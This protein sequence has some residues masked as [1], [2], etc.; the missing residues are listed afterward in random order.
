MM[1]LRGAGAA[2]APCSPTVPSPPAVGLAA[3]GGRVLPEYF[4]LYIQFVSVR[5]QP[6]TAPPWGREAR[7]AAPWPGLQ[8][9]GM[10]LGELGRRGGQPPGGTGGAEGA[11]PMGWGLRDQL[12]H[13]PPTVYGPQPCPAAPPA[14]CTPRGTPGSRGRGAAGPAVGRGE[15]QDR[16]PPA[17]PAPSQTRPRPAPGPAAPRDKVH[18]EAGVALG[19]GRGG[20]AAMAAG[21]RRRGAA[22]TRGTPLR[23]LSWGA[24]GTALARGWQHPRPCPRG[25]YC[26]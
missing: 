11:A 8:P 21:Q 1:R 5:Q 22:V 10:G 19:G 14:P 6:H 4:I 13:G 15:G 18:M 16:G 25:G 24:W 20:G 2:P 3:P 23:V 9:G 7:A 12:P 26:R 17:A